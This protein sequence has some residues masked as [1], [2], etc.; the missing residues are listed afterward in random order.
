VYRI[1]RNRIYYAWS[2]YREI[3]LAR[4]DGE[5]KIEVLEIEHEGNEDEYVN[6]SK[7]NPLLAVDMTQ[8]VYVAW[9]EAH[10]TE[11]SAEFNFN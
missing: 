10:S 6:S 4:S 11:G 8:N 5:N 9:V 1:E 7:V 3:F 2:G